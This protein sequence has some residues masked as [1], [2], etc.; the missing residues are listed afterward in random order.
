M[1]YDQ[2]LLERVRTALAHI[3]HVDE[4]K[5]F[6]GVAFMVNG[7]MC[8]AVDKDGLMCRIDPALHD[9]ALKR[10]GCK[11][12]TMKGREFKG[13]VHVNEDGLKMKKDFDYWMGLSLEFNRVAKASKRRKK[14]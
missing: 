8:V 14:K 13:Y 4:K 6:G 7:K 5:M 10:K 1:A 12:V 11:P 3:P 2:A 9:Q